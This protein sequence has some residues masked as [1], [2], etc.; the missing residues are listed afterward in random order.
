MIAKHSKRNF[1]FVVPTLSASAAQNEDIVQILIF[2]AAKLEQELATGVSEGFAATI[3][4]VEPD[5]TGW[6]YLASLF[7]EE[8]LKYIL[9]EELEDPATPNLGIGNHKAAY[10]LF[11]FLKKRTFDEV[12]CLDC[13]GLAYYATQAKHLGLYVLETVFVVHVVGGI[14]FHKEAA[15]KLVDDYGVLVDDLLE[16]G[17]LERAD[18]IYIH[19]QK[20]WRWYSDKI[21]VRSDAR[22]YDLA[23][24]SAGYG[25]TEPKPVASNKAL[26]IVYYG[27]L[28]AD[29]GLPLFCDVVSRALPQIE[30]PVEVFF[31]GSPQAIGGLDAVSYIRLRSAKWGVPITIK[32]E[33]SLIDEVAFLFEI[34]GIIVSDTV[35]RESLR[36]R[37]IASSGLL[38]LR[39][40]QIHR[41]RQEH[42]D[43]GYPANPGKIAQALVQM[44]AAKAINRP[45]QSP[46]LVELWQANRP[47]LTSQED[48]APALPLQMLNHAQPK[49]SVCVTHF[50]RPQKLRTA[51][52]SLKQQTYKNFEVIVIDDGS[53]DLEVQRELVRIRQE[54]EPMGWRL[55][56]QENRYLGAA[57]N[58]GASQATGDYLMFMDDDNVAKP[59]EISTLVAV[60]ERTG[61][62]IVTAFCDV[63]QRE[64]ELNNKRPNLRF[65]PFGS[66][67]ALGALT[68]CYGDANALYAREVFDQLGGFTEDYGLG[69]EDWEFFCRASLEGV[70]LVCVPEPLF[71]YRMDQQGMLRGEYAQ[72]H[73]SANLRRHIRPFLEKLPYYQ[74]KLVQLAQGLAV[75]LPDP[76]VGPNTRDAKPKVLRARHER[77]PYARVAIIMRTKDRPLLLRRAIR[78]VLD[79]TFQDWLLVLLNDGGNPENVEL[80]V[81][82]VA[83]D[84]AGRVLVLHHS[85]SLGMQTAA[86]MGI[87]NC[88]SEFIVIHDDDDTW[89]P[90]FL[91]STVSYLDDHGWKPKLGGVITWSELIIEELGKDGE[92]TV[93]NRY[94]FN[95]K[96]YNISLVD[97]AI[98]N[99]FPPISFLFRRAALD[100][101]G[102]FKEQ[103]G[104]LGDWE[105]HLRLLRQF[106]ID[107]IPEPL[108]NY[109][110]RTNTTIGVYGNSVH[111]QNG[112]H[113]L[114]RVELINSMVRGQMSDDNG[115]P[116]PHLMTLGEM[117]HTL[118]EEQNR[119]FQRLHDYIWVVEQQ[120]KFITSHLDG[121]ALG[122]NQVRNLA[123]NG[124]FRLW[125]GLGKTRT[126]PDDEY[127]YLEI[128]PGFV[129]CYDGHQVSYRAESR[130]WTEDGQQLPF[131]KT[132]LHLE[133]DGQTKA[134][135]WFVLECLIQSVLLLSGQNISVSGVSRLKGAQNWIYVGGRYDLGDGR[136]LLWPTQRVLLSTE[137]ERW[138]CSLSCPSV[139][140]TEIS[141]GHTSRI[142]LL[143]PY[144]QPFEFD[145]TN[146]QVELGTVPTEFEYNGAVSFRHRLSILWS[147]IRA[148]SKKGK[149]IPF[150]IDSNLSGE[151]GNDRNSKF[152]EVR[153]NVFAKRNS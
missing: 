8:V 32:R 26:P 57:R 98:E 87:S 116:L 37:L 2:A 141:R 131:G 89:K 70:K 30:K 82:E 125:P 145:L 50:S 27:L 65:T 66:D 16:R 117:H 80:V 47:C 20:A 133:H 23:W 43:I 143:L 48:I 118:R 121:A 58:Y 100:A 103:H 111:T 122:S 129:I 101:V 113:R 34:G 46:G 112:L 42:T 136:Q 104:V 132:Y 11:E 97:L 96:L 51:L 106:D 151:I 146:F 128:C 142:L 130:K 44:V 45:Q 92:I 126:G 74:A 102:R 150:A 135:S 52:A 110:H 114:K 79:Q 105:F 7:S 29:G 77:L 10:D 153:K 67:P 144:D 55:L 152:P 21:Q 127:A 33:F 28:S 93:H 91:A 38:I 109:H 40:E 19:D 22:I 139:E 73:K 115:L 86:N 24:P 124:D 84:L 83:E 4:S 72:F 85:L 76:V 36:S 68:N 149:N 63:F 71:W 6:Q 39:V 35:R 12:H 119:E 13:N 61:A 75:E 107:V 49:I 95:D 14:I 15:D 41:S 137:F 25:V 148:W 69:L 62:S 64:S 99:R 88:D 108:A 18:V 9:V 53:P 5:I 140:K 3:I 17:S 56:V 134:G 120:I 78:S 81:D 31:V 54:I 60:A 94:I 138:T 59:D 123:H 1:A 147:K 90:T